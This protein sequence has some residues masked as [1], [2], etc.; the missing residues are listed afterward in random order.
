MTNT[1]DEVNYLWR[2]ARLASAMQTAGLDALAFNAGPSLTYLTGLH[3][4][5][6]ERPAVALFTPDH[7]PTL[8]L[9]ELET[10]KINAASYPLQAFPYGEDPEEWTA[11]FQAAALATGLDGRKVGVEPRRLRVLELRLLEAAAHRAKFVSAEEPLASQ[12]IHKDDNELTA[13]RKAVAVA[14]AALLATLPHIQMGMTERQLAAELS[15]Q[16][17]RHGSDPEFPFA[18]IVASGPNSANPHAFPTERTLSPVDLLI[19][20]WGASIGGYISDLTRTFSLGEPD[21]ELVNIAQ[22]LAQAN[23]AARTLAAPGVTA[24]QVDHAARSII[25]NAGFGEYFI[26]RTGHG[27]GLDGHEEPYI[28]AGN[29]LPLAPGM[30]FTIE[31]GVYLPDHGGVRIE[32]DVVITTYGC[33][34]LSD[35]PREL[36]TIL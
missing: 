19:L 15:L 6:S 12:R 10:G 34:S 16:L 32:D 9:P 17:L 26:H 31:P 29:Q 20:D 36:I 8:I 22:V 4:H 5:L 27:I 23:A 14:Q 28:R 33:E 7:H 3:F 18:P 2:H 35:L 24:D 30:T 1:Q 25:E 21:P 13:M 11:A